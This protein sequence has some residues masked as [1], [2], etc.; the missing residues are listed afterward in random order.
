MAFSPVCIGS[1]TGWRCMTV[2]AV[3]STVRV[4][5]A[6][7]GPFPS[8]GIP[9][10]STTRPSIASPTGTA[11]IWPVRST[12][13]PSRI[14]WSDPMTMHPMESSSRF[15]TMP[16]T[17]L[18]NLSSSPARASSNPYT[19]A[20][21]SPTWMTV[22]W[23]ISRT[24]GSYPAICWRRISEISSDRIAMSS[25]REPA[26]TCARRSRIFSRWVRILPS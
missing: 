10:A 21:L 4:R 26:Q 15:I 24:S 12:R 5:V 9:R 23:D 18:A 20:M 6:A 25:S 19:V 14:S 1:V 11:A 3:Y 2:G 17:P 8:V 16:M 22:P 13:S 7:M